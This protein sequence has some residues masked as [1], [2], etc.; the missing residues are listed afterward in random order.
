[1][2]CSGRLMERERRRSEEEDP[3]LAEESAEAE[4]DWT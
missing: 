2:V 1:M 3:A 4:R